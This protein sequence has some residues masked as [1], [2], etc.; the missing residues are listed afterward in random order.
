MGLL[1]TVIGTL[2]GGQGG[3]QATQGE[4]GTQGAL[5][6]AVI[7]MLANKG[8][9][10]AVAVAWATSSAGSPRAPWVM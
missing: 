6:N 7:G 5:L 9:A 10:W 2:V 4:A 8:A 1:D 3:A